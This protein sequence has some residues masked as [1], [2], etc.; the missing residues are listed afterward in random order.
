MLT[1]CMHGPQPRSC[2]APVTQP[3]CSFI[4]N[5]EYQE[6]GVG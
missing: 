2:S 3:P 6:E 4:V 5:P 1:Y